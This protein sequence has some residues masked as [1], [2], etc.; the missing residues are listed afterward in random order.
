MIVSRLNQVNKWRAAYNAL[1]GLTPQ[2]AVS[3]LETAEGG[4]YAEVMW[5][6]RMLEKR[7][8][9]LR[10]LKR[11]RLSALGKLDWNIKQ[12]DETPAAKAQADHLRKVYDRIS[13]LKRAI[14]ALGLAEFR[15][16]TH[17]EKIYE[18]DNPGL[19]IIELE[20]VEQW[21]WVREGLYG[22][23]EYNAKAEQVSRG[24][25]IEPR[26]FVIREVEDPI[27]EIG[28][29]CWL[30]KNLSQKD[31][32]GFVETYGIPPLFVELPDNI[33]EGKEDEYQE[34]AED[35]AA[36]T[37]GVLPKGAK[38][39]TVPDGARGT[40]PFREHLNYQDE[41]LVLAGTSGK[42]TML[43][44]PAGLD[45][46]SQGDA[47]QDTFDSLAISEAAEISEVFQEQ[48]D[49]D[50]LARAFPGQPVLAYFELA[51]E[52]KADIGQIL[53]HAVKAT[54][55]GLRVD[56]AE[57][58][59]KT[60]YKLTPAPA[61]PAFPPAG[62]PAP[63]SFNRADSRPWWRSFFRADTAETRDQ[64]FRAESITQLTA[65][66]RKGLQPFI[67]RGL[68]VLDK[69]DGPEFDAALS[70]FIADL[71]ALEAELRAADPTGALV[72]AW[73][74]I[75]SPAFISGAAEA[76]QRRQGKTRNRNVSGLLGW[77]RSIFR[78]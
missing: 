12:V 7:E 13:N 37:R 11:L 78:Q 44:A 58:S 33:P 35:V 1:R 72:N 46:G 43:T 22:A 9:T 38:I 52:D 53:D 61:A 51:A 8:P 47:H 50:E 64:L 3:I 32:D 5:I 59:E 69:P 18:A 26:H 77:V 25:P 62:A 17:L 28:F 45:G 34:M 70:K 49:K 2:R 63:V 71:P 55:A 73:E 67:K 10:G 39:Q 42:L 74:S 27:N 29:F 57:L 40:N 76:A 23:W 4:Q 15:G 14:L 24:L 20:F 75:L 21:H 66:E 54:Q 41:Q 6:Y 48:I 19:G 60:G 65:V 30:R 56:A 31:W 36:D 16:F 68:A